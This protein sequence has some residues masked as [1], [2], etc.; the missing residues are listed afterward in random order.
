[1][2]SGRA[3]LMLGAGSSAIKSDGPVSSAAPFLMAALTD[4]RPLLKASTDSSFS[5]SSRNMIG[6]SL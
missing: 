3:C 1:M 4:L 2:D 6:A 5:G